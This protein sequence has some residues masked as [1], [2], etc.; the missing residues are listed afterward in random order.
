MSSARFKHRW[1]QVS[2]LCDLT[3]E[4]AAPSA[5]HKPLAHPNMHEVL[6]SQEMVLR[7]RAPI[8]ARIQSFQPASDHESLAGTGQVYGDIHGQYLDLMRLFARPESFLQ[9]RG[10]GD[11]VLEGIRRPGMVRMVTLPVP[12]VLGLSWPKSFGTP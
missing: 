3:L 11:L 8:K 12:H 9:L 7:L 2:R 4:A 5:N 10:L 1:L 6:K